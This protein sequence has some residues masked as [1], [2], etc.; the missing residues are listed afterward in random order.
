MI[1]ELIKS[2][3]EKASG[4]NAVWE[5]P[6]YNSIPYSDGD[7]VESRLALAVQSSQDVSLHSEELSRHCIDWPS[8]YHLSPTRANLMRPLKE[9]LA[10]RIL[11]IGAGC[12]A[13][14]RYLGEL[15]VEVVALEGSKRRAQIA[16]SRTRDLKNVE[17]V[18]SRFQDFTI[19]IQFDVITLIGVLEYASIFAA[20]PNAAQ[21]MIRQ[22]SKL[23]KPGG[24]LVIAIENRLGL[25][26]LAGAY[27]DHVWKPM[28]GIEDKYVDNGPRTYG[29]EEL[30][31][32]LHSAGFPKTDFL[33]PFP[34]YK[35][36][37]AILEDA[38]FHTAEF[39]TAA[40]IT[41]TVDSDENLPEAMAFSQR[42]AWPMIIRNQLAPDL[43][44]SFLVVARENGS[45]RKNNRA[46]A[47]YYSTGRRNH[48]KKEASFLK[49]AGSQVQIEYEK[50]C[51]DAP[52]PAGGPLTH[53]FP[54]TVEYT[55]GTSL[56]ALFEGVLS[57]DN[58]TVKDAGRI[59][60]LYA[61]AV[62]R[63]SHELG[64]PRS[65]DVIASSLYDATP[66]NI[67][68]AADGK[69]VLIDQEWIYNAPL[70]RKFLLFRGLLW[71]TGK[72]SQFAA[73]EDDPNLTRKQFI[74]QLLALLDY[75]IDD[76]SI[77][78]YL[79]IERN[80][81][82]LVNSRDF[83]EIDYWLMMPL[84]RQ[85]PLQRTTELIDQVKHLS[86]AYTLK[87]EYA[88]ILEA[89]NVTMKEQLEN[90]QMFV[91]KND[92]E[93]KTLRSLIAAHKQTIKSLSERKVE[94]P[95]ESIMS[96]AADLSTPNLQD[97]PQ[98]V[99]E[100]DSARHKYEYSFD[101][102]GKIAPARVAR[103]VGTG[104]DVLEVGSGPGSITRVL[105]EVGKNS[106]T[107][108]EIDPEAI[109]KVRPHCKQVLSC[110]LNQADWHEILAGNE[111][112]IVLAADVLEH[113]YDPLQALKSMV[114]LLNGSGRIVL[115]L[116]HASHL[117]IGCCLLSNN[118]RYGEWGLLDKTHIRF[119]SLQNIHNLIEAAGLK[120]IHAE[121][122]ITPPSNMEFAD[123][124]NAMDSNKQKALLS[125]PFS[126]VY[127]VVLKAAPID[128][129]EPAIS[130]FD[131]PVEGWKD[132]YAPP[133][134]VRGYKWNSRMGKTIRFP[135]RVLRTLSRL[136]P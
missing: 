95:K 117:G 94:V 27:E 128:A 136:F 123:L 92:M 79:E 133:E 115:S 41:Q 19:G 111:F 135:G 5:R 45:V 6:D 52:S 33:Y 77:K 20:G 130:L 17:V 87:A 127:Q 69:P 48:F 125:N 36:P 34:D 25:K 104:R 99:S 105:T 10:G 37:L 54:T 3:F 107:A 66:E 84:Y 80:I 106:V 53:V 35:M 32:L 96:N 63:F 109:E 61:D 13:I 55:S 97:P 8:R 129:E 119:F 91:D 118:F 38:A 1:N 72:I 2:G 4:E 44:N 116:P 56:L 81:S 122:V 98:V 78:S 134:Y 16:R 124:W 121:F 93:T 70:T 90:L 76:E 101:I 100:N 57:K 71:M 43:S 50:I 113:L 110:D 14:T 22:I 75:P 23:L 31:Q 24:A 120:I 131:I 18:A 82:I 12:G 102:N 89:R 29:K 64:C 9:I 46:I 59:V 62:D 73:C 49:T 15:G 58:W 40:L 126:L 7:D 47:H 68:L 51:P 42:L 74:T 86:S 112:D 67:I 103:V 83:K 30:T 108:L 65:D 114:T 88:E 85:H 28:F 132:P 21:A 39:N 60:R 11:E 26:Y